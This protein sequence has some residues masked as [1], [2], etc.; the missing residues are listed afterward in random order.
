MREN[1]FDS[2]DFGDLLVEAGQ[3]LG[4]KPRTAADR[5]AMMQASIFEVAGQLLGE[6]EAENA[7]LGRRLPIGP[8]LEG[9]MRCLRA[10]THTVIR[11]MVARLAP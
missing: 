11:E 9:E 8:Q 3:A 10:I 1:P 7:E 2:E 6:V 4:L 5:L